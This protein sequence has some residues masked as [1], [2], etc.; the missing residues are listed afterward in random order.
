MA[1]AIPPA[2]PIAA[3][4]VNGAVHYASRSDILKPTKEAGQPKKLR[5]PK[6]V[7]DK[8]QLAVILQGHA[9]RTRMRNYC[10][11]PFMQFHSSHHHCP[12]CALLLGYYN[13]P[14]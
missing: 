3:L 13:E 8:R 9:C 2:S 11:A 12:C 6:K 10:S 5:A 7:C 4:A 14:S 1:C